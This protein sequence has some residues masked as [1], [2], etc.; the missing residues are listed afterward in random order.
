M[1]NKKDASDAGGR[2]I[3]KNGLFP[4]NSL[5]DPLM[6]VK[7]TAVYLRVSKSFLDKAR[8]T[9]DGPGFIRVGRKILYRKSVVDAWLQQRQFASTSQYAV[10]RH[11]SGL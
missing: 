2:A 11:D 1:S 7:E 3:L 8:L 4:V 5:R 9:G 10:A 6:T